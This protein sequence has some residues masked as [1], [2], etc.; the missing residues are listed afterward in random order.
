MYL[1]L[2]LLLL[3]RSPSVPPV[4]IT[5]T[6]GVVDS[7]VAGCRRWVRMWSENSK[8]LMHAGSNLGVSFLMF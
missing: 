2:L 3:V 1:P 6:D 7:E 5:I 4:V 8:F